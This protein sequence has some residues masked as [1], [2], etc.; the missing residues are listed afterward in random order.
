[1][2]PKN[3]LITG[4]SGLI[5]SRLTRLLLERGYSVSHVG[6]TKRSGKL[7]SFVWDV[8]QNQFDRAALEGVDTIVHLAGAGVADKRWTK[9]RK[10]E[11]LESRTKSTQLLFRELEKGNHTVKNFVSASA[12]GYYGFEN[13]KEPLTEAS[14]AG[15]DFLARV[16]S[17]WEDESNKIERLG[18][19]LVKMRIGIVLSKE[20]GALKEISRPVKLFVGSPLGSGNQLMSWIHLEDI[21]RMFLMVIENNTLQGAYN[22][23]GPYAVTNRQLTQAI[24]KALHRPLLLPAVPAFLLKIFL[25]EMADMVLQGS[26]VSSLKICSAGFQFQFKTLEEAL[27]D[28]VRK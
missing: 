5:G 13:N 9:K 15:N 22:A 20:G 16:T 11:I 18:I 27:H 2:I 6:R 14:P 10:H 24:A 3:I 17:Q 7:R 25:G 19:R 21:V 8:N 4:A 1:L 28:L 23:T 12:I 26:N